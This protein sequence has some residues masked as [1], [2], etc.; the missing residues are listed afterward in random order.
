M[1]TQDSTQ[2]AEKA[3]WSGAK[4]H[5]AKLGTY[6]VVAWCRADPGRVGSATL[7]TNPTILG[8]G[9]GACKADFVRQRPG[10]PAPCVGLDAPSV[11]RQQLELAPRGEGLHVR[12]V[13]RCALLHNGQPKDE[14]HASVGD[15]VTLQDVMVFVVERRRILWPEVPERLTAHPFGEVDELG[16]V[17]ESEP[18]WQLRRE[19]FQAAKGDAHVL[20]FGASGVGKELAGR[21]IH[22]LSHRADAPLISRNAATLPESLIDAE[23]FGCERNYPNVG[24]PAR[25]GLIASADGGTLVLDEVGEL[26][27]TQQTHLLRVMDSGGEY[28]ALGDARPRR[29]DLRVVAMTNRRP[30]EL[31]ADFLARFTVRVEI[32]P[33]SQRRSDI[34]LLMR[35]LWQKLLLEQP[36]LS[37]RLTNAGM[38]SWEPL[39]EPTFVEQILRRNYQH[40][41]RELERILRAAAATSEGFIRAEPTLPHCPVTSAPPRLTVARLRA[42]LN[43]ASGSPTRAAQLLGL[44]NRHVFYRLMKKHGIECEGAPQGNS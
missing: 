41:T 42:A 10:A 15:T 30:D 14:A 26:P 44:K 16:I 39:V 17:G 34:P 36:T 13:G 22:A 2:V 7:I 28:Q 5:C 32:P 38:Q 25:P 31:R 8:R 1:S 21:A 3:P 18:A 12:N 37:E 19:L 20:I 43:D 35:L 40:N 9:S 29:A 6:L 33:L 27:V 11:S 24:A 4:S 23:L